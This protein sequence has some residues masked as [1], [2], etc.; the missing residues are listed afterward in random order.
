MA[1]PLTSVTPPLPIS[2]IFSQFPNSLL[3]GVDPR[4]ILD[5]S[6]GVSRF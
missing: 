5:E 6:A 1:K 2:S 3:I 4:K